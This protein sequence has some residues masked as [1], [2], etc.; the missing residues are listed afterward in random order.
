M[1]ERDTGAIPEHKAAEVWQLAQQAEQVFMPEAARAMG[2]IREGVGAFLT[3]GLTP[4]VSPVE[5]YI[6]TFR[7]DSKE[8][9]TKISRAEVLKELLSF[10]MDA[11]PEDRK[12]ITAWEFPGRTIHHFLLRTPRGLVIQE[13]E[14]V[15]G[16]DKTYFPTVLHEAEIEP[17]ASFFGAID[18]EKPHINHPLYSSHPEA[19]SEVPADPDPR[20]TIIAQSEK[21]L[22]AQRVQRAEA[23]EREEAICIK[24]LVLVTPEYAHRLGLD[25][26]RPVFTAENDSTHLIYEVGKTVKIEGFFDPLDTGAVHDSERIAEQVSMLRSHP[27]VGIG[28]HQEPARVADEWGKHEVSDWL[29][30]VEPTGTVIEKEDYFFAFNRITDE[31]RV[32]EI[33]AFC[34]GCRAGPL[35][36]GLAIEVYGNGFIFACCTS[37]IHDAEDAKHPE[38]FSPRRTFEIAETGEVVIKEFES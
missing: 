37:N 7:D 26:D 13:Y 24:K 20:A 34:T 12:I 36:E 5:A 27:R 28:Y 32:K 4:T 3:F 16:Q 2:R 18:T 17:V 30:I 14:E 11:S 23:I 25:V 38:W 9:I 35:K 6:Q 1:T 8:P 22:E 29:A 19:D 15:D 31:L 33:R 21:L 10:A